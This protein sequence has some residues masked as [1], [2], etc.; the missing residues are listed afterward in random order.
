MRYSS[1]GA[2]LSQIMKGGYSVVIDG[3][4]LRRNIVVL[5]LAIFCV[6]LGEKLWARFLSKYLEA[7]GAGVLAIGAFGTFQVLVGGLDPYPGGVLAHRRGHKRALLALWRP[8][9]VS[10]C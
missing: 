1:A 9:S 2:W 10:W 6:G 5:S 4:E 3:L 8:V 7:L